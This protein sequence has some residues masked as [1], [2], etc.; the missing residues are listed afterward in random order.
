MTG[1]GFGLGCRNGISLNFQTT[2]YEKS[3]VFGLFLG[4][5]HIQ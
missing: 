3:G 2:D 4:H 1:Q 5:G